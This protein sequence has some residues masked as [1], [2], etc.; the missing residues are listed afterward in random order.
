VNFQESIIMLQIYRFRSRPVLTILFAV[1][2]L[3]F[4]MTSPALQA[5]ESKLSADEIERIKQEV[6]QE[7]RDSDFLQKEIE[8]GIGVYVQKQ[9]D[10][11]A[12]V[13]AAQQRQLGKRAKN[14]RRVDFDRD[15][16][17]GN[18][19]ARI[20]IIEY[21]DF[22]CPYCK[23]FHATPKKLVDQY[24]GRVNWVYRHFPLPFHNPVAQKAAEASE[25]IA[26]LG[27]ND[28]FWTFTDALYARGP[29]GDESKALADKLLL[30]DQLGLDQE[31]FS[32]CLDSARYAARVNEDIREGS[33][34]GINGTPG[35]V[36]LNNENGAV[37][38]VSGAV[39]AN[40]LAATIEQILN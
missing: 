30:V 25:C 1:F 22:E 35:T 14:V 8:R 29:V 21:S 4:G 7:L 39:P 11:Q 26:E 20:S 23:A 2:I 18:P 16:V 28:A 10:Q 36:V 5:D 3:F 31:K 37:R 17:F 32:A 19:E 12:A 15:H 27:G 38:L 13:Q 6:M 9:R 34:I 33:S 40:S 24:E